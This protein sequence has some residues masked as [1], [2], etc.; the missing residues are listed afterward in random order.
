EALAAMLRDPY[1]DAVPTTATRSPRAP[2]KEVGALIAS[3]QQGQALAAADLVNLSAADLR[4][5]RNVPYARHG[6]PFNSTELAQRFGAL[7]WYKSDPTFDN[8]RLTRVDADNIA[9]VHS[10]EGR[11][12]IM[13]AAPLAHTAQ[14]TFEALLAEAQ[15][16]RRV[17]DGAL[18]GLDLGQLRILRNTT[19]ARHGYGFRA[20][21]LRSAFAEKPWYHAD[22][23]YDESRLSAQDRANIDRVKS[24]E[25]TL[26]ASTG[27][28]ALRDFELRSQANAW[29]ALHQ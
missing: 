13:T 12:A 4:L 7:G 22:P 2:V 6:Y 3:A 25:R 28:E 14:K 29:Q 19:Y 27:G 26:L 20:S 23:A 1:V 16:G 21:D 24:H 15:A 9:L 5:L 8:N 11:A 18:A 10:F 17:D